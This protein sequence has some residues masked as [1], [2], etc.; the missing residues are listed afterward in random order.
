MIGSELLCV[1]NRGLSE[2]RLRENFLGS[3]EDGAGV[4]GGLAWE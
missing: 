4:T 3:T 1:R 2:H